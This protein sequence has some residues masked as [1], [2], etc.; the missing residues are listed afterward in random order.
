MVLAA[1]GNKRQQKTTAKDETGNRYGR[2]LVI[3][4]G[5][6]FADTAHASWRCKCDCGAEQLVMGT[7]LRSGRFTM[8]NKCAIEE[9]KKGNVANSPRNAK[10]SPVTCGNKYLDGRN[11]IA[12]FRKLQDKLEIGK[13]YIVDGWLP[14]E[15]DYKS[16]CTLIA[17]YPRYALFKSKRGGICFCLGYHA[18]MME[19]IV[20]TDELTPR[21]VTA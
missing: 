11:T 3:G 17:K 10:P 19:E 12:R 8:C 14:K 1:R 4:R 18:I 15:P 21:R 13:T 2:L 7:F 16:K 5:F 20:F 9:R 6:G